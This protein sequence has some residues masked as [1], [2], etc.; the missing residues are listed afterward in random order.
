M[1]RPTF[2]TEKHA[3]EATIGPAAAIATKIL[4]ERREPTDAERR[5][6]DALLT[7]A[8]LVLRTEEPYP[9]EPADLVEQVNKPVRRRIPLSLDDPVMGTT[10]RHLQ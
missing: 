3:R 6:I 9:R 5:R 4:S 2:K 7:T 1:H 10:T 8:E